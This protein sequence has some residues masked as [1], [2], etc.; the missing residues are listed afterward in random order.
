MREPHPGCWTCGG[1]W[2]A[3][4]AARSSGPGTSW[5][6][7][8]AARGR[9]VVWTAQSPGLAEEGWVPGETTPGQVFVLDTASG[10][11]TAPG[12]AD[13]ADGS[14]TASP[15]AGRMAS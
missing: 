9:L 7:N 14:V 8:L 1:D 13:G 5:I 4:P 3:R 10:K 11:V 2:V 12:N 15:A 6:T